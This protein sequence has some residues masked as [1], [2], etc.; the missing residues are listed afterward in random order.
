MQKETASLS[1]MLDVQKAISLVK[2]F[3]KRNE[4]FCLK[5]IVEKTLKQ[6]T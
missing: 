4:L 2:W 3:F 5:S 1:I 6:K